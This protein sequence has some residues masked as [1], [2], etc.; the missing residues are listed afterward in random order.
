MAN[1]RDEDHMFDTA[2]DAM[3]AMHI[4][5]A[6]R[7]APQQSSDE[8][9]HLLAQALEGPHPAREPNK[10][11]GEALEEISSLKKALRTRTVI[12]QATGMLMVQR[13]LTAE[14]AFAYLRKLSSCSNIKVR[15]IATSMIEQANE[16]RRHDAPQTRLFS[17]GDNLNGRDMT[18]VPFVD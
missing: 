9:I 5:P 3:H 14:Q 13:N 6:A 17:T 4:A 18:F 8:I 12:G 16:R 15:D 1:V 7:A 10:A 2:R 11:L